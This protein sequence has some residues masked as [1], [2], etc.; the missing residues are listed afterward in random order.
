MWK[1]I[2]TL[3][4]ASIVGTAYSQVIHVPAEPDNPLKRPDQIKSGLD[5]KIT[6]LQQAADHLEAA[7]LN[8]EAK[9]IRQMV[10]GERTPTV[11]VQLSVVEVPLSKL[12]EL[13][14]TLIKEIPFDQLHPA[15]P[16]QD[17]S[18][19]KDS[20]PA[21]STQITCDKMIKENDKYFSSLKAMINDNV[22]KVITEPMLVAQSGRKASLR[23][24]GQ[25]VPITIKNSITSEE[26][27]K[28]NS[29]LEKFKNLGTKIDISPVV[30]DNDTVR[31]TLKGVFSELDEKHCAKVAGASLPGVRVHEFSSTCDIKNGYVMVLTGLADQA[32]AAN[33]AGEEDEVE[34]VALMCLIKTEIVEAENKIAIRVHS[35][36]L[37]R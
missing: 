12:D 35:N 6:H 25:S 1:A 19:G 3:F 10:E 36:S 27:K 2:F 23:L 5:E 34:P 15:R 16:V 32:Q 9:K 31:V 37:L 28:L 8:E 13:G 21:G 24:G 26:L 29:M 11:V 18:I 22:A 17:R 4:L 7:G 20:L 14:I 30:V 33:Q